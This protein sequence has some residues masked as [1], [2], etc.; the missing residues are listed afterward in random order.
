MTIEGG[1]QKA[2]AWIVSLT[3][4]PNDGSVSSAR[5]AAI[6]CVVVACGIAIAGLV[7]NRQHSESVTALLGGG[8][9]NLFART[10]SQPAGGAS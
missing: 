5:V 3:R 8:A 10:R 4:D 7:L 2:A 9:A 6:L 1:I